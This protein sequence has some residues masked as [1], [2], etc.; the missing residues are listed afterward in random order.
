MV[1]VRDPVTGVGVAVQSDG[2]MQVDSVSAPRNFEISLK[3]GQVY[4]VM[5][6]DAATA[7]NEETIYL[8]NNST[9]KNLFVDAIIIAAD[10]TSRWR[11]KFVTGTAGGAGAITPVN[12]NKT[13]S[14][15]ADV[16]A[17][18]DASVTGLTDD[19]DIVVTDVVASGTVEMDLKQALILGQNDAIAVEAE[20]IASVAITI[21]FHLE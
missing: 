11:L 2:H 16:S 14:N 21:L 4:T 17:N 10:A 8:K 3:D 1:E 19:G 6:E 9:D 7:A 12:L 5:S 20:S 15:A 18:G 13:S